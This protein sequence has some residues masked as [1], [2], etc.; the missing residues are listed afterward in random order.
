VGSPAED[1]VGR[2]ARP[3]LVTVCAPAI[4]DPAPSFLLADSAG[5]KVALADHAGHPL[6][7]LFWD[8]ECGYCRQMD[9]D[10][11]VWDAASH[12]HALVVISCGSLSRNGPAP[13]RSVIL[14]DP[15]G[16][17][18]R[19]YGVARPPAAFHV[20][21]VGRIAAGPASCAPAVL[22]LLYSELYPTAPPPGCVPRV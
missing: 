20:D 21:A 11:R 19:A 2:Q 12:Q 10:L 16:E 22:H 18:A 13:M 8:P 15:T 5:R 4:G 3:A 7:V 14:G 9:H 17:V 6:V 1:T